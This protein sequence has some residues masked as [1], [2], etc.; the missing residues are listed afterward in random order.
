M[1]ERETRG[2]QYDFARAHAEMYSDESRTRKAAT[3]R[4]VLDE[5][6]GVRLARA[7]CVNVGCSTGLVDAELAPYVGRIEGIDI[8]EG[9]IRFAQQTHVASNLSFRIGDAMCIDAVDDSYD[10]A[11]CS[12]V[13]EHVPDPGRLMEEIHR[14]LAPGGVCYFA[15]T[16]R[17]NPVEQHY[18]LPLLSI[19]PVSWAHVYLRLLGRGDHYYERHFTYWGLR[20]LVRDFRV[21][22]LTL[23]MLA[24]PARYGVEYLLGDGSKLRAARS[25]SRFAYWAFPGYIWLLWKDV[26]S[27]RTAK[28]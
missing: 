23:R 8:D 13:Y 15:A 20:R 12:Q 25:L 14:V 17:L 24:D 9:A 7:R 10:I 11:I 1:V 21:E 3:M 26:P 19:I 2:Y 28:S 6:L 27:T 22:D 16:N 4:L 5:A 18:K